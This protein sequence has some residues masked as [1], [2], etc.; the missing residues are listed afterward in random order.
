M[1]S[2]QANGSRGHHRFALNV[3]E[4]GINASANTSSVHFDLVLSPIQTGWDWAINGISYNISIDGQNFSGNIPSYDGT[5]TVTLRSGD[6]T[7]GHNEN[8]NKSIGFSFS[9]NDS[10]NRTYTPGSCSA[11]GS[12]ALTHIN[13]YPIL[14]SGV[15]FTDETNPTLQFTN[16]GLYPVRVKLEAGGNPQLIIRDIDQNA[17][18]YTFNLTE[19]ERNTLRT[20]ATNTNSLQVRETVCAMSGNTELNASYKDYTMTIVNG[21]PVFEDFD[22]EDTNTAITNVTG[23]DQVLVKGLSTL[24]AT[25]STTNKMIAVKEATEKNYVATIDTINQ[26]ENY[27][28]ENDVVFNLGTVNTA[29]TQRLNIRAY[30]SR[31]NST[32]VYKDITVY[33]YEKPV[34]NFTAERLNNF[35]AQTNLTVNG[36]F[37]SLIINN[38]EKNTIQSVQYRYREIGSNTWSSWN[39]LAF[40]INNNNFTCTNTAVSLDNTKEFEIEV[41]VTDNLDNNSSIQTIDVGVSIFFISSNEKKCYINDKKVLV[42]GEEK[43]YSTTEKVI[44]TWDGKP[45][46]GKDITGDMSQGSV[47]HGISNMKL[48]SIYGKM[49]N[50][51]TG[52]E[53]PLPSVRPGHPEYE[54]GLYIDGANII[55][56]RGSDVMASYMTFEIT[57]EYGKTTD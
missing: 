17:T 18:S 45:L 20:I 37:S 2:I 7:I 38:V 41:K 22:Y 47:A 40:T 10:A 53:F 14:I 43:V 27:D 44:G 55:I 35:E 16:S 9:I 13:R 30:D 46:Y 39:N 42:E 49:T 54:V 32:L 56:E 48:K 4:T 31:N 11:S 5:S 15:N 12:M 57:I 36:S 52:K 34:V 8:G 25:I 3:T 19:T 33:D 1:A 50:T 26:S 21:N 6:I 24:Q 28:D 51:N 23:D 29:G